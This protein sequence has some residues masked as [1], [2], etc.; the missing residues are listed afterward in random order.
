MN[1]YPCGTLA[2]TQS[3]GVGGGVGRAFGGGF[4][5]APADPV[6]A[7]APPPG[8][9][10]R[11]F[12]SGGGCD[13]ASFRRLSSSA[14]ACVAFIITIGCGS[15]D[16]GTAC[17]GG[18]RPSFGCRGSSHR[19]MCTISA[20]PWAT[21]LDDVVVTKSWMQKRSCSSSRLPHTITDRHLQHC[22]PQSPRCRLGGPVTTS[23][24]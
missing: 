24:P 13:A 19:G 20:A 5:D 14:A 23:H 16:G 10:G 18:L 3:G 21:W 7:D 22:T 9:V 17:A 8:E 11:A 1:R 6:D 12:A 15:Q 2:I 4:A